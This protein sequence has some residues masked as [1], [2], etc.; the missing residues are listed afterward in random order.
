MVSPCPDQGQT[1]AV[2][3]AY[4][5]AAI[6]SQAKNREKTEVQLRGNRGECVGWETL[7]SFLKK[8]RKVVRLNRRWSSNTGASYKGEC[9]TSGSWGG[10]RGPSGG[11]HNGG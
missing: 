11:L 8:R 10:D 4:K 5:P 2:A 3:T 1:D 6:T 9:R 7:S